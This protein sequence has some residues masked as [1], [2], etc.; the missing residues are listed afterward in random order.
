MAGLEETRRLA[1]LCEEHGLE[2]REILSRHTE[3]ELA[4]SYNGIGPESFPGWLRNLLDRLHPSLAPVAFIHDVEWSDSD[5][6]REGFAA[7]NARF[8]ANGY[9]IARRTFPWWSIRRWLVMNDARRFGNLCQAFGW[10]AWR[11]PYEARAGAA[12]TRASGGEGAS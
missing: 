2:G 9:R 4:L 8:K 6:T 5:G 3:A 11:A 12:G 7:S 1:A 10:A